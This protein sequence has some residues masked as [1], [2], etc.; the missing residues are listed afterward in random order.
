[1]PTRPTFEICREAPRAAT[2]E[3]LAPIY[4]GMLKTL[5]CKVVPLG[6]SGPNIVPTSHNLAKP[7]L[8][9][10]ITKSVDFPPR[11]KERLRPR[12]GKCTRTN[13]KIEGEQWHSIRSGMSSS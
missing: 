4:I 1:M 9:A 12:T 2:A 3:T 8:H 5:I 11:R 13:S 7:A 10:K 6:F